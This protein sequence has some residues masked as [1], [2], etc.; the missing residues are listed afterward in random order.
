MLRIKFKRSIYRLFD[1]AVVAAVLLVLIYMYL[2]FYGKI[3]IQNQPEVMQQVSSTSILDGS[4]N[5]IS[6]MI[7]SNRG[8]IEYADLDEMPDMLKQAFLITE[9]KRF[10][11]HAGLDLIGVG[12]AGVQNIIH[13]DWS[14]GGSSITQQ[15]ARNLYLDGSKT[16]IRKINELSIALELEKRYSKDKILEMY[17]NQIYMGRQQYGVKAAAWRYFGV[18]DLNKLELWQIA[19][20]AGIPKGPSIYN[21]VDNE[22][23]S[24]ERRSVV[25]SLMH[26]QGLITSKQMKEAAAVEYKPP[27]PGME[28]KSTTQI[29][30][31]R[32]PSYI[33][34]VDAVIAEASLLTGKSEAEIRSAGWTIRTGLDV[35]AQEAMEKTFAESVWFPDDRKDQQVQASMVIL[36]QHNG[37][38]KAIM[39]GRKPV[40]GD[41]NRALIDARQPGSVFKPIVA[42]GPA[43]ESGKF[44]PGTMLPDRPM[45]YGGYQP[46]NLGGRYRGTVSMSQALQQS[47][48]APSVWLLDQIGL[49]QSKDFAQKLGIEIG[50]EDTNL[51][52]ALGGLH[53]GISPLKLAQAYAVFAN[54][55]K[56]NRAHLIREITDAQGQV[57]YAHQ[58]TNKQVITKRTAQ[59]MTKMLQLV[60]SQGTGKRAQMSQVRVAGKTG[61]TQAAFPNAPK[62]A[63]R[64]IWFAGYTEKWTG[65]VWMGFDYTDASHYLQSGSGT[66]AELFS[67]VMKQAKQ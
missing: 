27:R 24:K 67:T 63:N 43:L 56:F 41:I 8:Y 21:P 54:D 3:I 12:R 58:S 31:V 64:D 42:Y 52:I 9:D 44:N 19:T 29:S 57:I 38:V 28:R 7:T 50:N 20:L 23:L 10:Y 26:E 49:R 45:S 37:E 36:D 17:L 40:K 6:K 59:E 66:A 25:L 1:V 35:S 16:L 22:L 18:D 5:E 62:G 33:S 39:G 15:L 47:I 14:Q 4:G 55:G 46:S 32:Q 61:T 60:V 13:M 34:A 51:S 30:D 48:N 65:V 2:F 53:K 11:R